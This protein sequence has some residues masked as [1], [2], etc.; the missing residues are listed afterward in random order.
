M[1]F[2]FPATAVLFAATFIYYYRESAVEPTLD[3]G[4]S[5]AP[6]PGMHLAENP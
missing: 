1:L 6:L 5:I 3:Y 4:L 2:P